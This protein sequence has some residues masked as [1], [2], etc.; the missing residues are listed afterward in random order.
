MRT[1]QYIQL[2]T[3]AKEIQLL[4]TGGPDQKHNINN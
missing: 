1:Q 4:N 2:T 3:G